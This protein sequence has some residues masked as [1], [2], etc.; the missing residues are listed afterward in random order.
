MKK[1][2]LT[3]YL[4][5]SLTFSLF[6]QMFDN[7][8]IIGGAGNITKLHF[9]NGAVNVEMP[10]S[11]SGAFLATTA[12]IS[13]SSGSLLFYT[14]GV[15]VFNKL[16][17]VMENGDSLAPSNYTSQMYNVGLSIPQ[18]AIILPKPSSPNIYYLFH[19]T[20]GDSSYDYPQKM[21]YSVIDMSQNNGDGKVMVK[22]QTVISDLLVHGGLTACKH[23]NGNDW[24]IVMP[25]AVSNKTYTILLTSNGIKAVYLEPSVYTNPIYDDIGS[26]CFSPNGEKYIR[27]LWSKKKVLVYD[28]DR[29]NGSFS[30]LQVFNAPTDGL[31][32]RGV[33]VSPNSQFLYVSVD[34]VLCQY[35]LTANNIDASRDTVAIYDGT[36]SPT[37]STVF[38]A[39]QLAPDGKIYVATGNS[40]NKMHIINAPDSL[41]ISCNVQQNVINFPST[42]PR[43]TPHFPNYRLSALAEP[44][45]TTSSVQSAVNSKQVQ[46]YPNPVREKVYIELPASSEARQLYVYNAMGQLV[47]NQALRQELTQVF[48]GNWAKGLY[49]YEV[50]FK[51]GKVHGK[52]QVE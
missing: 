8:W 17:Q 37:Q 49:F 41:G 32:L 20:A 19:Y 6:S 52:L 33:A 13:D 40:T 23:A 28:F 26:S 29:C 25:K 44:C 11:F 4:M 21:L 18:G 16:G 22:N 30:N 45:D 1:Q 35:D 34:S 2:L 50:V 47:Y 27:T 38:G 12:S 43:F 24:W 15:K 14:N 51:E 10:T 3:L 5:L 46:V 7:N 42:M 31:N 39:L 36:I 9:S 48:V